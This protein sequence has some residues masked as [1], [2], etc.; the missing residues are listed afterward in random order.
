M[1]KAAELRH[2]LITNNN[3]IP[4]A[5]AV[6]LIGS[7]GRMGYMLKTGEITIEGE[8]DEREV[9]LDPGFKTRRT[10]PIKR[11]AGKRAKKTAH[12]KRGR[13]APR[14]GKTLKA[15]AE[16][17]TAPLDTADLRTAVMSNLLASVDNLTA[18]LRREV[19]GVETNP[20]L[21]AAIESTER[22]AAIL[23][24]A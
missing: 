12:K 20:T 2:K 23:K 3:R 8:G 13:K 10:L 5:D 16:K 9:V 11:K 14:S 22:A 24:A 19:D 15:L 6:A 1:S 18:T 4:Y 7:R 17:Y 21:V